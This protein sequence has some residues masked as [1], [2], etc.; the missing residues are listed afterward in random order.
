MKGEQVLLE[1][2][3]RENVE[4]NCF[5][6]TV[7][8]LWTKHLLEFIQEVDRSHEECLVSTIAPTNVFLCGPKRNKT[9]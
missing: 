8:A 5:P 6:A 9:N 7:K 4:E 2:N 1:T 3:L